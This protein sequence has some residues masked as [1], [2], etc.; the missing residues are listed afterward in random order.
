[1]HSAICDAIGAPRVIRFQYDGGMRTVEPHAYGQSNAGN[2]LLRAYQLSGA[3][4]SGESSGWK[5][6]R[7]D[8]M[9]GI[10]VSDQH[11]AGPRAGYDRFDDAM[12]HVYCRL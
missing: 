3:S 11:F 12:R 5:L 1:M 4:R 6:F 8:E 9:T 7:V 2:D 10:Q